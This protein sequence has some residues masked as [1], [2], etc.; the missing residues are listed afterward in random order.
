MPSRI[1]TAGTVIVIS[2]ALLMFLVEFFI[3][4]SAKYNMDICCRSALLG[5]ENS[6]GLLP[7]EKTL[8]EQ[9]LAGAGF[10]NIS[11]TATENAKR[12]GRLNLLVEA[13]YSYSR[14]RGLLLR[15]TEVVRM[16]YDKTAL[17]RKVVN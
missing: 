12:G 16:I 6:G 10:E 2:A 17:S 4:V 15:K 11:I 1:F 7:E 8:L 5:M 14:L 13:D 9:G 3:P